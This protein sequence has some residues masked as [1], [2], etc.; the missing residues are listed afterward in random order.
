MSYV[1][2]NILVRIG[3]IVVGIVAVMS[4]CQGSSNGLIRN[5][6]G[7]KPSPAEVVDEIVKISGKGLVKKDGWRIPDSR[8]MNTSRSGTMKQ[9]DKLGNVILI[10][11]VL[12]VPES[13]MLAKDPLPDSDTMP[14]LI[15]RSVAI[16][17]FGGKTYSF[18]VLASTATRNSDGKYSTAGPNLTYR[19]FDEDG[20][21]VFEL[22]AD[23]SYPGHVPDWILY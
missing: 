17:S 21:G 7:S 13:E 18:N 9:Y 2:K 12:Q 20:D 4:S 15:T 19:Y 3:T 16:L 10:D 1:S 14:Q 22:L 8:E 11:Y 5:E 6:I 23:S